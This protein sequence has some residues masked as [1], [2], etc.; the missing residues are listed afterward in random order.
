MSA[1]AVTAIIII[2]AASGVL[3]M[4]FRTFPARRSLPHCCLD[5]VVHQTENTGSADHDAYDN[6]KNLC[7]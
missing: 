2:I 4:R 3:M 6:S 1:G 5:Q 7:R